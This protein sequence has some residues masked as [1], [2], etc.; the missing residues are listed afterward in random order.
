MSPGSGLSHI[1][2]PSYTGVPNF[3]LEKEAPNL[4]SAYK[5]KST[6]EQNSIDLAWNTLMDPGFDN[7]RK[8]IYSTESELERFRQI[9]VNSVMA[10]DIFDKKLGQ[11]RKNR[12]AKAFETSTA[13]TSIPTNVTL[14]PTEDVH[15]KA[16]IVIEHVIQASD[17]AHT[18]QHWH[19][20]VVCCEDECYTGLLVFEFLHLKLC[21][22]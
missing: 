21:F 4:A 18:M 12:W 13:G 11:L 2:V 10:T 17:V 3:V 6:A 20:Y 14:S 22:V 9:L 5:H 7:L 1:S 19:I 15:R 8:C 16:T